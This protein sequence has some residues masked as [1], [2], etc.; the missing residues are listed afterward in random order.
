VPQLSPSREIVRFS[1]FEADL[2]SGELRKHGIRIKLQVQPFQILRILLER[3]GEVVTREELQKRI[4]PADTF[5]DFE[6]GLNNA[7]KKLREALGDDAGKQRFIETLSKRGYRFNGDVAAG[8]KKISSAEPAIRTGP[9]VPPSIWHSVGR[10]KERAELATAFESAVHGRGLL[11]CVAGEPGIGK[12][13]LVEDFLAELQKSGKPFHLA[14]GRCSQRLA[15]SEAY[16]P[17]LEALEDLL[18]EDSGT[19]RQKLRTL[20]PSWFAQ[21]FPLSESDPSDVRLQEYV[22]HTTQERVK[23]E[24]TAFISDFASQFPVV[25]FFDD[26]HWADLS[27][28]DLLNHLATKLDSTKLLVIVTYRPSELLHWKHPFINVKRDFLARG[29]SREFEVEFLLSLIHI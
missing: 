16:L 18:R 28:V 11:V 9:N 6:H 22:T 3:P 7:V 21:L 2:R 4:W 25:L 17:F 23:R 24:F 8:L 5:V 26:L 12:T 13:T 27:T 14:K 29:I 19:N 15:G 20:A 1:A 10:E